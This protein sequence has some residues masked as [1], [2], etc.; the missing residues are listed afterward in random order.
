[1]SRGFRVSAVVVLCALAGD[2]VDCRLLLRRR[3]GTKSRTPQR[4][5]R[6]SAKS[7][8]PS[9]RSGERKSG[10]SQPPGIVRT[11]IWRQP[12]PALRRYAAPTKTRWPGSAAE[13]P[14]GGLARRE[15]Q[16]PSLHYGHEVR[17]PGGSGAAPSRGRRCREHFPNRDKGRVFRLWRAG[18]RDTSTGRGDDALRAANVAAARDYVLTR[19]AGRQQP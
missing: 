13:D 15:R 16:G 11:S 19:P 3:R 18:T 12:C 10:A 2:F 6:I 9:R 4:N 1:M 8:I 17:R 5:C 14:G 7:L